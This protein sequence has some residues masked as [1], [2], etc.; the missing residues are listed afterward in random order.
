MKTNYELIARRCQSRQNILRTC[1][2][3]AH[4]ELSALVQN[5]GCIEL[6]PVDQWDWGTILESDATSIGFVDN[7]D[8][9]VNGFPVKVF[10][11]KHRELRV[12]LITENGPAEIYTDRLIEIDIFILLDETLKVLTKTGE[13]QEHVESFPECNTCD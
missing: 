11:D 7:H 5:E 12:T 1:L 6:I 9:Y 10:E 3:W 4:K 8:I 2:V 13:V